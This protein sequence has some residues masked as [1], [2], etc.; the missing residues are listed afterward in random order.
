M[1]LLLSKGTR[2]QE[3]KK[4][5]GVI[6]DQEEAGEKKDLLENKENREALASGELMEI[7]D[8]VEK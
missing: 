8:L 6:S 3:G 7:Q 2:V 1:M 4:A 5:A